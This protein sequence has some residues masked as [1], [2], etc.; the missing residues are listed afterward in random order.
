[1]E[2]LKQ[3]ILDNF[4]FICTIMGIFEFTAFSFYFFG[5]IGLIPG[6][7]G[8]FFSGKS[9]ALICGRP[10]RRMFIGG[11]LGFIVALF[12]LWPSSIYYISGST[13]NGF[14]TGMI[15]ARGK[16]WQGIFFYLSMALWLLIPALHRFTD[17]PLAM[18]AIGVLLGSIISNSILILSKPR[19]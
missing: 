7:I 6:F 8:G 14:F 1:M 17:N 10:D 11:F 16:R 5:F 18:G 2:A 3:R 4:A 19:I 9:L 13:I 15:A 12:I